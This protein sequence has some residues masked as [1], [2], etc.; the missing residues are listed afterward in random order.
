MKSL[1]WAIAQLISMIF[2]AQ[3][4][5]APNYNCS[6]HCQFHRL[7]SHSV[8]LDWCRFAAMTRRLWQIHHER[9]PSVPIPF[10]YR[11]ADSNRSDKCMP[12]V[13]VAWHVCQANAIATISQSVH[14]FPISMQYTTASD[15]NYQANLDRMSIHIPNRRCCRTKIR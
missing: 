2:G 14:R 5:T 11:I 10:Q 4:P 15:Q 1:T 9:L 3:L 13:L 12:D 6:L 8:Y 7:H